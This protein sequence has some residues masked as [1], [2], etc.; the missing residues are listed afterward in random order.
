MMRF[1]ARFWR[2][3]NGA[4]APTLALALFALIAAGGIAFDYARMAAL[5]TELQ[6]AADQAALAAA[7]QLD[8]RADARARARAAAQDLVENRTLLANDSGG[9]GLDIPLVDFYSTYNPG[10]ADLDTAPGTAA[11]TDANARF[12]RVTVE[13]RRANYA[14]TPIVQAFRSGVLS[15][16]ALAGL[17][18]ATCNLPP[19]MICNPFES[20]TPPNNVFNANALRGVGIRLVSQGGGGPWVPGNFGYLDDPNTDNGSPGVRASLGW[21]MVPGGCAAGP[22]VETEPGLATSVTQA[23]NTRF[24]MYDNQACQTGGTCRPS[25]NAIKDVV[26]DP[27]ATG[28]NACRV[29]NNGWH[30]VPSTL[31]EYLPPNTTP[32][33]EAAVAGPNN[34]VLELQ[35]MGHPQDLCHAIATPSCGQV[36]DGVWDRNAYFYVNHGSG[37]DW[38]AAMTTAGYDPATVTRYQVYQWELNGHMPASRQIGST[39]DHAESA[40]VCLPPGLTP[41]ATSDRRKISAALVNCIAEGVAGHTTGVRVVSFIDLF[42]VEPSLARERTQQGEI[43]VELIGE[44]PV[45]TGGPPLGPITR[46]VPRLLE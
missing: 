38:Q 1:A 23:L 42:L 34:D 46:S 40:P 32:L 28:G 19:V 24:D 41:T 20:Q 43:Y 14:L 27:A 36:G 15:A 17:G 39:V 31:N 11:T 6:N 10:R 44:S 8:Q 37:F 26:R 30:R 18:S 25:T 12:V 16:R 4:V 13:S 33:S 45:G 5:D 2:D 35:A 21:E 22:G 3:R 9:T 29:H 7:G